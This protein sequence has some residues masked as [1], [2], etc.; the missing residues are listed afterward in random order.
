LHPDV[1]V[2]AV[3]G[4]NDFF[5]CARL[6]RYFDHRGAAETGPYEN[7]RLE[8]LDPFT[9]AIRATEF[10]Q[11]TYFLNNPGDV[12]VVI[13]IACALT[14]EMERVCG[15]QGTRLVCAYLPPPLQG[16][17]EILAATRAI[18]LERLQLS[19]DDLAV[20]DRIADKWLAFV[21]ARGI[22]HVDLR[23][24]FRASRERLYWS[25]NAH[26]NLPYTRVSES[27]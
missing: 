19:A 11:V 9:R 16:Q 10:A 25:T 8:D 1:F 18:V 17:P 20:S 14:A 6:E 24:V 3:Y 4:G 12:E 13:G 5:G 2:L 7:S 26:I 22:A 15:A 23:P 27:P 21:A